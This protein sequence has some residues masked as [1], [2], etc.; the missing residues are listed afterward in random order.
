M[1]IIGSFIK[2]ALYNQIATFRADISIFAQY[3]V[4]NQIPL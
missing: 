3:M 4:E 1:M 2:T